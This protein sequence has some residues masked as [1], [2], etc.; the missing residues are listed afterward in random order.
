MPKSDNRQT[1]LRA[2]VAVAQP[3]KEPCQW[4]ILSISPF[5]FSLG[6]VSRRIVHWWNKNTEKHRWGSHDHELVPDCKQDILLKVPAKLTG[7][8]LT[9]LSPLM[10]A[11]F[12]LR[13]VGRKMS[14]FSSTRHCFNTSCMSSW[15]T[16]AEENMTMGIESSLLSERSKCCVIVVGLPF[17][18]S[19]PCWHNTMRKGETWTAL[20]LLGFACT[21]RGLNLHK[22]RCKRFW[23]TFPTRS[24]E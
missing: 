2:H 20:I 11:L 13:T 16:A 10:A 5:L 8:V 12:L 4:N 17:V 21:K 6:G 24:Y 18:A 22:I 19:P 23:Y 1:I 3:S 15:R 7:G 14:G 9:F